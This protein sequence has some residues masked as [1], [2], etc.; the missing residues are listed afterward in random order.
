MS[1]NNEHTQPSVSERRGQRLPP[2][3]T[4]FSRPT[5]RPIVVTSPHPQRLR[6]EECHNDGD[7]NEQ[8]PLQPPPVKRESAKSGLRSLFGRE[9]NSRKPASDT[10]L[11]GVDETQMSAAHDAPG[12]VA[13]FSP[14]SVS[15]PTMVTSSSTDPHRTKLTS[16]PRGRPGEDK[17]WTADTG[18]KPPPLF[19]AYPQALKNDTLPSPGLSVDSILRLHATSATKSSSRDEG[20]SNSLHNGTSAANP[21]ARKKKDDKEKK[22]HLRTLSETIDKAEWSQK[23]YILATNGY[24]LQYSGSGKHDRLPEKM[25][26]LGPKYLSLLGKT[27]RP[28]RIHTGVYFLVWDSTNLTLDD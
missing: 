15:T 17:P 20:S 9:K 10:E 8:V 11:S 7:S 3:Q 18:W 26:R 6:P 14:T 1:L 27:I 21:G 4:N 28:S 12:H 23:V 2:L 24:I 25:L 5:S 16:K 22:K 19:Q 13:P